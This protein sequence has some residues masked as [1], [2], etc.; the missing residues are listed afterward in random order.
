M[1]PTPLHETDLYVLFQDGDKI[2]LFDKDANADLWSVTISGGA[3]CGIIA[4]S[5]EW[6]LIG[7]RTL[8]LWKN[9]GFEKIDDPTLRQIRHLKP[10][11]RMRGR[12][13]S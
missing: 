6:V 12:G 9:D 7:G 10:G 13:L 2:F 5:N 3:T 11:Q 4:L 1:H 8:T